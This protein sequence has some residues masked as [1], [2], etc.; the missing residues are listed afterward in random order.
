MQLTSPFPFY[1][2][3]EVQVNTELKREN[4]LIKAEN[5]AVKEEVG[6]LKQK[7]QRY[8][9]LLN[10]V[11]DEVELLGHHTRRGYDFHPPGTPPLPPQDTVSVFILFYM[12][13]C[14][15]KIRVMNSCKY[16]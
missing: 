16:Q 12:Q 3:A 13:S 11:D 4:S 9:R 8:Q 5:E 2:T 6:R 15:Y 10:E 1:L 14:A 7:V